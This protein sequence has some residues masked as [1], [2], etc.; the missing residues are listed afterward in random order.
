MK[1]ETV[2]PNM[3]TVSVCKCL[4]D[5]KVAVATLGVTK[6]SYAPPLRQVWLCLISR[7]NMHVDNK[8]KL[9]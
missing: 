5:A 6:M 9:F 3:S 1:V 7:G 8:S 4:Q 2:L